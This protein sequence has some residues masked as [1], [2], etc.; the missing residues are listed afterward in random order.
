MPREGV[1][2]EAVWT[3]RLKTRLSEFEVVDRSDRGRSTDHLQNE[4][5]LEAYDP[6]ISITQVGIVDCSPR[7]SN[8]YERVAFDVV[9]NRVTKPYMRVMKAVRTRHPKRCYVPRA[10]FESNLRTYYERARREGVAVA[11]IPIAPPWEQ[12]VE[13][14]PHV[15]RQV[16]AYNEVYERCAE[17]F[18]NVAMLDPYSRIADPES[19]FCDAVH[20]NEGGHSM[21]VDAVCDYVDGW[22][23]SA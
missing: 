14:S 8:R 17:G 15:K 3:H 12:F 19:V 10:R 23:A 1:E 4:D 2:Y 21:V 22:T 5:L 11:S 13:K 16:R 7:Y 20:L 9:P 6:D 18:E